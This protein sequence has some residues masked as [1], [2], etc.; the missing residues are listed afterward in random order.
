MVSY[1]IIYF[2]GVTLL[3]QSL[4]VNVHKLMK[5][6]RGSYVGWAYG[7]S[8]QIYIYGDENNQNF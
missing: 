4:R 5:L 8:S 1:S 3:C 6:F 2:L 7:F